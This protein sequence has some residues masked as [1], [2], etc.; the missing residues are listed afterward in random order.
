MYDT[1]VRIRAVVFDMDGLMLDTEPLY[2]A[3]WKR[4]CAEFGHTLSDAAYTRLI[5]RV[6]ADAEQLL[7]E[8]F[9]PDFHLNAFRTASRRHEQAT[10]EAGPVTK[11]PG[12]DDLIAFLESRRVLKAV[13][14]STEHKI[15]RN[16]LHRTDLLGRFDAVVGGDEVANGKPSPDLFRLAASRLGVSDT[17][18]LVLEDSAAGVTA[19]NSAGM[20][21]F[22]VPDID[23]IPPAVESLADGSFESLSNVTQYLKSKMSGPIDNRGRLSL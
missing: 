12:L 1:K 20:H 15:A 14:T 13:A 2:R 3:A 23:S 9:G 22:L 5:G 11:K 16:L 8:E 6:R 21:V 4:A 17:Q 10:L 19:A 18:C 7:S